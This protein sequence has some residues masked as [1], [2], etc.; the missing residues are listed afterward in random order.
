VLLLL[1]LLLLLHCCMRAAA[2]AAL[3]SLFLLAPRTSAGFS[4][5]MVSS[6]SS[7]SYDSLQG[8]TAC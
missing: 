3:S 4:G 2:Y 6:T 7:L 1:L 8:S 5:L